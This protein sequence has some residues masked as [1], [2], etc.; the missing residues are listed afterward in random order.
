MDPINPSDAF[1]AG[2]KQVHSNA[3]DTFNFAITKSMEMSGQVESLPLHKYATHIQGVEASP[4]FKG[5]NTRQKVV[6]YKHVYDKYVTPL[7]KKQ[8]VSLSLEDWITSR[9]KNEPPLSA[10]T[11]NKE[12]FLHSMVAGASGTIY[13]AERILY[14]QETPENK[15]GIARLKEEKEQQGNLY[16]NYAAAH[17]ADTLKDKSVSAAGDIAGT[18]PSFELAEGLAGPFKLS[19]IVGDIASSAAKAPIVKFASN[20]IH[21]ATNGYLVGKLQGADSQA[22]TFASLGLA[23]RG[24]SKAGKAFMSRLIST[25]GTNMVA[26]V[27]NQTE[28][29]IKDKSPEIRSFAEMV[30]QAGSQKQKLSAAAYKLINE[31][32]PSGKY[33]QDLSREMREGVIKEIAKISPDAAKEAVVWNRKLVEIS[34][35][36]QIQAHRKLSPAFNDLMSKAE[37]ISGEPAAKTIVE[38]KGQ[39]IKQ[40]ET[41]K[42]LIKA[43][44]ARMEKA[45]KA[46]LSA[47]VGAAKADSPEFES[48]MTKRIDAELKLHGLG[49]IEW[50]DRGHKFLAFMNV[51]I[52]QNELHGPSQ[53]RDKLF[54]LANDHLNN[55]LPNTTLSQRME[56]SD[57]LFKKLQMMKETGIW[58]EGQKTRFW[59]QS[60]LETGKSPFRHDAEL[61]IDHAIEKGHAPV[62]SKFH[63]H[64]A[65]GYVVGENKVPTG[66]RASDYIDRRHKEQISQRMSGHTAAKAAAEK[67]VMGSNARRPP[68]K[69][70]LDDKLKAAF[71]TASDS[72][73]FIEKAKKQLGITKTTL[74]TEEARKIAEL[75]QQLEVE[76]AKAKGE[77]DRFK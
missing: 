49:D 75:A 36:S 18:L 68:I 23:G 29:A 54:T 60:F 46:P 50:E 53:L 6:A 15:A 26:E 37:S 25:G 72:G 10:L 13:G 2:V 45:S 67:E 41:V 5:L 58:K 19:E 62:G 48:G 42:K 73:S 56:M 61:I 74:T 1:N 76:S 71:K 21:D 52:K 64:T 34:D 63:S 77:G 17:F 43:S 16:K 12:K 20:L 40:S 32:V 44:T 7:A 38:A 24:I 11:S 4:D 65:E 8:G 3:M 59:R 28:E 22:G 55:L 30:H 31:H 57:N 70:S 51:M 47:S 14:G 69:Q 9:V 27:I 39:E 66:E 35:H 33:Y